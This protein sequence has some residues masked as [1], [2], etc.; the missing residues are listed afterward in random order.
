MNATTMII[1]KYHVSNPTN[2]HYFT[3]DWVKNQCDAL[4]QTPEEYLAALEQ[5]ETM[6]VVARAELDARGDKDAP[7][8]EKLKRTDP[9]AYERAKGKFTG[10]VDSAMLGSDA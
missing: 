3:E 4:G 9:E 5:H 10:P 8:A 1:A 6:M 2:A 7:W